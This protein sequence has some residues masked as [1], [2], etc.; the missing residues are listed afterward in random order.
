MPNSKSSEN[1]ESATETL[2]SSMRWLFLSSFVLNLFIGGALSY[3]LLFIRS[4]QL[5]IHLPIF[6]VLMPAN[7]IL[8]YKSIMPF[9]KFDLLDNDMGLN[10]GTVLSFDEEQQ[11]S[12]QADIYD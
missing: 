2:E 7:V 11:R 4:L 3:M 9:A 8:F 12:M 10:A 1:F 6:H 5:I